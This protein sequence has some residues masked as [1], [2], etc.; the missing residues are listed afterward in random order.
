MRSC[1]L[2][3]RYLCSILLEFLNVCFLDFASRKG[4]KK[5]KDSGEKGAG[6]PED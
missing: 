6:G 2:F 3:I 5:E 1:L 4:L